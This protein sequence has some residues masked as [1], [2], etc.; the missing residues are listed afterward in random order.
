MPQFRI[1]DSTEQLNTFSVFM[2]TFLFIGIVCFTAAL[3]ISY[4]RCQTLALNN[5]YVFYDLKRL[6]ASPAF[7]CREL[8]RQAGPVFQIPTAVGMSCMVLLYGMMLYAND[9]RYTQSEIAGFL[10]CLE[11]IAVI[12]IVFYAVYRRTLYG[13]MKQLDLHS[14]ER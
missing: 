5:A 3:V 7:L 9:N 14:S 1:L 10:V 11:V 8:R 6:G 2:M 4:T 13:L 12:A